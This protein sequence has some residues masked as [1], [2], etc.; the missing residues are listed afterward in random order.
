[1]LSCSSKVDER[2][3]NAKEVVPSSNYE[4]KISDTLKPTFQ[5]FGFSKDT[6]ALYGLEYDTIY[7]NDES[8]FPERFNPKSSI[9]LVLKTG[10]DSTLWYHWAF[11]DSTKTNNALYNWLDCFDKSCKSIKLYENKKM[12]K[13]NFFLFVTDTSLTYISANTAISKSDW[14]NYYKLHSG[15]EN[16][17]LF[18]H[19]KKN[20]KAE[21]LAVKGDEEI[22][23]TKK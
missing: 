12:Q 7:L 5:D 3:I 16:W 10:K 8:F 21:W 19:Q 15:I 18:I 4:A 20:S 17:K 1:M 11:K 2:I 13:D 9:K 23:L 14:L 6:A 22:N